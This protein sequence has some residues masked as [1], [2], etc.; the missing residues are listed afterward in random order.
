MRFLHF[1]FFT[2]KSMHVDTFGVLNAAA[3]MCFVQ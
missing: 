2:F 3:E 1:V